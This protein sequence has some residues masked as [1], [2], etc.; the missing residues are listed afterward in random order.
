METLGSYTSAILL[1]FSHGA[2]AY[3]HVTI[4]R[5]GQS[6][7]VDAGRPINDCWK[8][9]KGLVGILNDDTLGQ[10]PYPK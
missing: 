2:V 1:T 10:A 9:A 4:Y 7:N 5:A 3:W 6:R 8:C